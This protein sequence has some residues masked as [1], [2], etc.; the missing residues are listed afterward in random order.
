MVTL[1]LPQVHSN[2]GVSCESPRLHETP[3]LH[4]THPL[5]LTR[6]PPHC[7][8]LQGWEVGDSAG[9]PSAS[10]LSLALARGLSLWT[11]THQTHTYIIL[12]DF[13]NL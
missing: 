4:W 6:L 13:P 7:R 12:H 10:Q 8:E 3:N 11:V 5:E 9:L 1:K 2:L